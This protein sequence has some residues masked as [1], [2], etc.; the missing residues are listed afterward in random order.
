MKGSDDTSP[1]MGALGG[2]GDVG[3]RQMTQEEAS[4]FVEE[5]RRSLYAACGLSEL[6]KDTRCT[7]AIVS[8]ENELAEL[9]AKDEMAELRQRY[10]DFFAK[11]KAMEDDQTGS[12]SYET[13]CESCF[14]TAFKTGAEECTIGG[15]T[16]VRCERCGCVTD[17]PRRPWRCR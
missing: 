10:E 16:P 1:L 17:S 9:L 15:I 3:H 11:V 13:L 8:A 7:E 14:G 4:E 5:F 2:G 6:L 12:R